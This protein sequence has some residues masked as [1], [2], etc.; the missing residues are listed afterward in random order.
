VR[1]L[2]HLCPVLGAVYRLFKGLEDTCIVQGDV[3]SYAYEHRS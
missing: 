3:Q 2:Y 1:E